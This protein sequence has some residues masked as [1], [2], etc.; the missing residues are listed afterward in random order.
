MKE[1]D[2]EKTNALRILDS[3][4][5]KYKVITYDPN[6]RLKAGDIASILD[7]E[8]D[9][10]FKTLVAVGKSNTHYVFVIPS[11]TTLDLKKAAF[12]THE[13]YIEMIKEKDLLP[14][15]GY[16][17]GGCSPIGMKKIFMTYFDESIILFDTIFISAGKVGMQIEIKGDDLLTFENITTADLTV[18]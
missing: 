1:R 10:V 12:Y 13:K 9:R 18:Y 2:V 15:T 17:H 4:G 16:V 6:N 11:N 3:R 7:E 8:K 5:I 14:L